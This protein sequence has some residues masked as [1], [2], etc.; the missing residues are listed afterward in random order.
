MDI[1]ILDVIKNKAAEIEKIIEFLDLQ[2]INIDEIVENTSID[3]AGFD[4]HTIEYYLS[5][6]SNRIYYNF[7][8]I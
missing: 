5:D 6:K 1:Q 2:D 4:I 7:I 8:Y 3:K